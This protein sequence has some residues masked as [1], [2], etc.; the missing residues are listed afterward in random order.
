MTSRIFIR[1]YSRLLASPFGFVVSALLFVAVMAIGRPAFS[2]SPP[3]L[4]TALPSKPVVVNAAEDIPKAA[5]SDSHD[6]APSAAR[7]A[8]P[9]GGA[10]SSQ[11]EPFGSRLFTGN[12]LRT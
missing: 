6:A 10:S 4:A 3:P 12:F 2:Q 1:A 7:P 5:F 8:N 11:P 9:G